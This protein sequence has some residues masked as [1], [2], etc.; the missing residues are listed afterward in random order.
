MGETKR[1]TPREELANGLTHALGVALSIAALAVLV[2][3]SA[4][5]GDAWRIVSFAIYGTSLTLLYTAST[6]YHFVRDP[7]AKRRLRI[8]DHS[9]IYLLIAG[10]YT[11]FMLVA[12]GGGWGWS[13]FGVIWALAIGG[14]A[15]TSSSLGHSRRLSASIYIA[16]GWLII[17]PIKP[18]IENLDTGGVL[19]LAGGGFAYTFGV[20][21][22][23]WERLPYNHAIWHLFVLAGSACHFFGLL[24]YVLPAS[25]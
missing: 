25:A 15:L 10:T 22:Y 21:F 23:V 12:L 3:L 16:M 19:W 17:I 24:F 14:I 5:Q 2:T 11:P 7:N 1:Y 20:V 13:I 4:Q 9:A 6:L 18:L 8:F